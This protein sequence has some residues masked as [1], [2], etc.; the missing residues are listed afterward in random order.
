[1]SFF[2]FEAAEKDLKK[3][4]IVKDNSNT[5]RFPLFTDPRSNATD[6]AVTNCNIS[7]QQVG[8]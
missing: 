4:D 8:G 7:M 2:L 1:M 5:Y 6:R 3:K